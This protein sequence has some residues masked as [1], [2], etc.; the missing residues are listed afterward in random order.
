MRKNK[1]VSNYERL[2]DHELAT[3]AGGVILGL[4]GNTNLPAPVPALADFTTLVDDYRAKLEVA[5]KRGSALEISLK[6]EARENLLEALMQLSNYVNNTA[7]GNAPILYSSGLKLNEQPQSIP[8]PGV[9]TRL[10]LRDGQQSGYMNFGFDPVKYATEYEY[11]VAHERNEEGQLIWG[12]I[13]RTTSSRGNF[14]NPVIPGQVYYVRLR[15]RNGKGTGDWSETV[16]LMA[17]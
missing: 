3:L 13:I 11:T 7:K 4:D 9:S 16:S 10:R 2:N 15:A 14:I 17:R 6:K 1:V 5:N 8:V 12:D